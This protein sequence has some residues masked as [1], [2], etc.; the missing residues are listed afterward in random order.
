MTHGQ[1]LVYEMAKADL[2]L[3]EVPGAKHNPAILEMFEKA[4]HGWVQDDETPWCAASANK[5]VTLAG[6]VG[7]GQ[8]NA[9]SFLKWGREVRWSDARRGDIVVL[10]RKDRHGPYGHVAVFER[11]LDETN[12]VELLGGNQDDRVCRAPYPTRRILSIR[13]AHVRTSPA[14]S[15][16]AQLSVAGAASAATSG[17]SA[18]AMLD[19][20][21][22]LLLLALAGVGGLAAL[23]VLRERLVAWSKGWR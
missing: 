8:L 3:A 22:Q 16:T 14:K 10:W 23:W 7:T 20:P 9:R 5:W 4:G 6:F 1:E 12:E 19:G 2:G 15:R 17:A 13:R 11:W 21:A 18:L